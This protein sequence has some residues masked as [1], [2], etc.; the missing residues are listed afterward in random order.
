MAQVS[1]A[2]DPAS[3]AKLLGLDVLNNPLLVPTLNSVLAAVSDVFVT[4]T[5]S[6]LVTNINDLLT[7][8]LATLLGLDVGGAD[9]YAV[10]RPQCAVPSLVG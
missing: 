9:V 1:V 4:K 5:I 6:P 2:I 10:G 3:S 7:G 8:P